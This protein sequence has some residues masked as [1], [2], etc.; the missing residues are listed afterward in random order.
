MERFI[1][2]S[3][4]KAR[5]TTG[6]ETGSQQWIFTSVDSRNQPGYVE[7]AVDWLLLNTSSKLTAKEM[8]LL[9]EE[10]K[11]N[12]KPITVLI[13]EAVLKTYSS[14]LLPGEEQNKRSH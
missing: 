1:T 4:C 13:R 14:S 7:I 9:Y 5:N 3:I 8:E 2:G 10:R 6:P 12:G 11:K